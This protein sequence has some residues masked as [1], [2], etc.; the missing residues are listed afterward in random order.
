MRVP[1]ILIWFS[2]S[3]IMNIPLILYDVYG[4]QP[5]GFCGAKAFGSTQLQII[6]EV[7]V[8]GNYFIANVIAGIYYYRLINWLQRHEE[9]RSQQA[10]N[11]ESV[12][13]TRSL[14]RVVKYTTLI[15][16]FAGTIYFFF[17]D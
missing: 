12:D 5:T 2:L 8:P 16:L 11:K 15:P 13:Y 17:T 9:S 1:L 4:E 6:F 10:T 3:V 7:C 14:M